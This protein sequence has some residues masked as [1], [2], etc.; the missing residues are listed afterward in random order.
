MILNIGFEE[1]ERRKVDT[2]VP[3]ITTCEYLLNKN[4]ILLNQINDLLKQYG[5]NGYFNM[6]LHKLGNPAFEICDILLRLEEDEKKTYPELTDEQRKVIREA[7]LSLA[8]TLCDFLVGKKIEEVEQGY[9]VA[10]FI[11]NEL[12]PKLIQYNYGGSQK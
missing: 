11:L 9:D 7:F 2:K 3:G 6:T 8:Y 1:R 4:I 5:E 10:M 12:S